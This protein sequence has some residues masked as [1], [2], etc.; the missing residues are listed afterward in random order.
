L[1]TAAHCAPI[2]ESGP[3]TSL[4]PS[5]RILAVHP[6]ADLLLAELEEP[7]EV[8]PL[9]IADETFLAP[10]DRAVVAGFGRTGTHVGGRL[11]VATQRVVSVADTL[12]VTG[13]GGSGVCSG[14]SGGPL[15]ARD[16]EGALRI[17]GVLERGSLSCRARGRFRNLST[18]RRWLWEHG[19]A[20]AATSPTLEECEDYAGQCVRGRVVRCLGRV[21][22]EAC[23]AH[24]RCSEETGTAECALAEACDEPAFGS[25]AGDRLV[26]CVGGRRVETRCSSACGGPGTCGFDPQ[27]GAAVCLRAP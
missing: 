13:A 27:N 4:E 25:C 15:L 7:A 16:D 1:L 11:R 14:D 6:E 3:R 18:V 17:V 9:A 24:E 8:P 20:P 10:G 23:G 5:L 22:T 12:V 19:V 21:I 26:Q 2:L